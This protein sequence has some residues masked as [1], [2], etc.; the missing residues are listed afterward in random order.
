MV[1][2]AF[3]RNRKTVSNVQRATQPVLETL[4]RRVMLSTHRHSTTTVIGELSGG[5][6]YNSPGPGTGTTPKQLNQLY[7]ENKLSVYNPAYPLFTNEGEGQMIAIVG[8]AAGDPAGALAA[9]DDA[10]GIGAPTEFITD[11]VGDIDPTGQSDP[12]GAIDSMAEIECAQAM[13]P[14]AIIIFVELPSNNGVIATGNLEIGVQEAVKQMQ[15]LLQPG[16]FNQFGPGGVVDLG[17]TTNGEDPTTEAQ[18]DAMFSYKY[19]GDISYI[20]PTSENGGAES[21]PATSPWVTAVGGTVYDID[22]AGNRIS[23]IASLNSGGGSS[24]YEPLPAFQEGITVGGKAL[25]TRSGPDLVLA[26]QRNGLGVDDCTEEYDPTSGTYAP[27]WFMVGGTTVSAAIFTGM[28]ADSNELRESLG[29]G[30]IGRDLNNELYTLYKQNPSAFFT[31][32]TGGNDT[33]FHALPGFDLATGMGAPIAN[34]LIPALAG[35]QPAENTIVSAVADEYQSLSTPLSGNGILVFTGS[36][37]AD[38]DSNFINIS[39]LLMTSTSTITS[40]STTTTLVTSAELNFPNISIDGKSFSGDGTAVVTIPPP[41]TGGTST[42][43]TYEIAIN[44]RIS[45]TPGHYRL[46]GN[47]FTID[48]RDKKVLPGAISVFQGSLSN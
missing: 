7:G 19:A 37:T 16:P 39:N 18:Y 26:S 44:G 13:A 30:V 5:I 32:I 24:E 31:D 45:G 4:E 1:F 2:K 20:A 25:R 27:F 10:E 29:L 36:G 46:S 47:F 28:V 14:H 15:G 34:T 38:V 6:I 41:A 8:A 17:L 23:E 9:Y 40:G 11:P 22:S 43:V 35:V 21:M 33:L 12:Y 3:T 48:D 42:T